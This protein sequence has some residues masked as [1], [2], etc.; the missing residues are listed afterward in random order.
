MGGVDCFEAD[1]TPQATAAI[2][3]AACRGAGQAATT[4]T[5]EYNMAKNSTLQ[6]F[7]VPPSP[8]FGGL[9]QVI[10]SGFFLIDG[11]K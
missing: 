6:A 5:P 1:G 8:C 9:L 4:T 11:C 10:T 3:G 2:L 7:V